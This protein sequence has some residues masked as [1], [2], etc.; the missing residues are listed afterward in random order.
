MKQSSQESLPSL[1]F[2]QAGLW[3]VSYDLSIVGTARAA[4]APGTSIT[5][6]E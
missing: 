5:S 6:K 2:L 1:G 3:D 4:A